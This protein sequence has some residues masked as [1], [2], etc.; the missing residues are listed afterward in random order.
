MGSRQGE[1]ADSSFDKPLGSEAAGALIA[2]GVE[3][4][5]VAPA[6]RWSGDLPEERVGGEGLVCFATGESDRE[7]RNAKGT[8]D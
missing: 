6:T 7:S 5:R 1:E 2:E 3:V 4:A 8:A